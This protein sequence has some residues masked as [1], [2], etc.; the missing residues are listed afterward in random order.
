MGTYQEISSLVELNEVE[1]AK[2]NELIESMLQDGWKGA[3]ILYT[4]L[5]LVTGSHRIVALK[6]IT[7]MYEN[8]EIEIYPT[9]L[10]QEIALDVT[11]I[12]N[13]YC[14][15]NEVSYEEIDFAFLS[16]VFEG[17]EVEMYKDQIKEW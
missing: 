1:Q 14:E 15:K 12:V 6:K 9:V 5:G 7:K 4:N 2:V 17:T 13:N 10:D 8:D 3:P 11:D 16:D